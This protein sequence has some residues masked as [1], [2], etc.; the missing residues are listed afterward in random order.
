MRLFERAGLWRGRRSTA[1]PAL[2]VAA[3]MVL[4]ST[5]FTIGS[6][7]DLDRVNLT[8]GGAWLASPQRGFV[9][10]IDGPSEQIVATVAAA[11]A[12][13][14]VS[15]T[16]AGTSAFISDNTLGTVA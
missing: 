6:G 15:V 8:S 9:T 14:G 11:P 16:Q 10:L 5:A 12:S 3:L 13:T 1:V 4:L 7:R 2:S